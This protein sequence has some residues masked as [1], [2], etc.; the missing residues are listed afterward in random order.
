MDRYCHRLDLMDDRRKVK[1][2]D[3]N[4]YKRLDR[5]IRMRCKNRKEEWYGNL[6]CEIEGLERRHNSRLL[7]KKVKDLVDRRKRIKSNSGCIR[8]K[9]GKLLFEQQEI[10]KR[11]VEY[12]SEL[13]DDEQ[14]GA[15]PDYDDNTL[16]VLLGYFCPN[17]LALQH[18]YL[19]PKLKS[20]WDGTIQY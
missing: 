19:Y 18:G 14:R 9:T 16:S 13:Y 7:H 12:I 4:E 15:R 5:D 2:Q 6:C 20:S 1:I 11:W 8:D 17:P 3:P 10:E